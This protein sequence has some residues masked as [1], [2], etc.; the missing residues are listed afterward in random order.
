MSSTWL[1]LVGGDL[2]QDGGVATSRF[3][4]TSNGIIKEPCPVAIGPLSL[5]S[6]LL[7]LRLL[8]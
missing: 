7:L 5:S 1:W 2:G 6:F 4:Y 8:L 3:L